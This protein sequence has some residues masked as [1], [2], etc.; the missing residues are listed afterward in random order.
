MY[1]LGVE[2]HTLMVKVDN[3]R[4]GIPCSDISF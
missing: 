4:S 2:G 1:I 3:P